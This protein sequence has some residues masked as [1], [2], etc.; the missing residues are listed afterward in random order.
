M[1]TYASNIE[2]GSQAAV[3]AN[4]LA[5]GILALLD[6]CGGYWH[7]TTTELIRKLQ[8]LDPTSKD[9][10]KLSARSVGRK[11]ASSLKGDLAA[12]GVEIDQGKGT[13][14]QRYLILSR[15]VEFE[16]TMPPQTPT[17]VVDK[18]EEQPI[19]TTPQAPTPVKNNGAT[20]VPTTSSSTTT[21]EEKKTPATANNT[22][23]PEV[24]GGPPTSKEEDH[25]SEREWNSLLN[26]CYEAG[27]PNWRLREVVSHA[28]GIPLSNMGTKPL[29]RAQYQRALRYL[30]NYR[31]G[32]C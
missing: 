9:F 3:E 10:Q 25:I 31:E 5:A 21:P 16:K 2:V 12:V 24:N 13:N 19:P 18:E 20:A 7:G 1:V 30:A 28:A 6:T 23:R 32:S 8:E 15:V 29:T 27:V 4:P 14:G 17:P 26:A 22:A 11:L